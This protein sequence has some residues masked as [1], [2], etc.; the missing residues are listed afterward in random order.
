[1]QLSNAPIGSGFSLD[2]PQKSPVHCSERAYFSNYGRV[3]GW[4]GD[5][6][7]T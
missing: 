6:I 7:G 5:A 4:E 2:L 1:M 3:R